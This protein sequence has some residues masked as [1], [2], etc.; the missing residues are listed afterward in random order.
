MRPTFKLLAV[1]WIV[2]YTFSSGKAYTQQDICQFKKVI[3]NGWSEDNQTLN[4]KIIDL[5]KSEIPRIVHTLN[6]PLISNKNNDDTISIPKFELTRDDYIMLMSYT[7]YLEAHHKVNDSISIYVKAFQGLSNIQGNTILSVIY[8]LA[9]NQLLV[10]SLE[11]TLAYHMFYPKDTQRLYNKLRKLLIFDTTAIIAGINS[12]KEAAKK[13][14]NQ[15]QE[16]EKNKKYIKVYKKE[17]G[18]INDNYWDTLIDAIKNN[19]LKSTKKNEDSKLNILKLWNNIKLYSLNTK[20]Y[21][22][23]KLSIPLTKEDYIAHAKYSA[24]DTLLVTRPKLY[25]TCQDY[26]N[27]IENNKKLLQKLKEIK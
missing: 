1:L 15:I 17:F 12:E 27:M 2:L 20:M 16:N 25:E 11:Q 13:L 7:K 5:G 23:R 21:L 26:L 24:I 8:K 18:K 4:Q 10:K 6:Q 19:T 3:K 14:I 9:M 22:Y